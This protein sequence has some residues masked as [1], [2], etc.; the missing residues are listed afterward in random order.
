MDQG[1]R[2]V[3][4]RFTASGTTLTVTGPPNGGVAPPG[5]YLLF[6]VDAAG[7]PSVARTVQVAKGPN[8]IMSA[9]RNSTGRCVDVPSSARA[10]RTYLQAHTCNGTRAQALTRLPDDTSIRVLGNCLDVPSRNFA[11]GQRI[12]TYPCNGTVAQRWQ[13]N[14]D[15]T[16]RPIGNTSVCLGAATSANNAQILLAACDAGAL[17]KWTW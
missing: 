12:R 10:I 16:I 11:A 4:L 1:Q 7:V 5:H 14:A 9:V 15:G 13:F 3:P 6:I 8:P 17:R 2:Y